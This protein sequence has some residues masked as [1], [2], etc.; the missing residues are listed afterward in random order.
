[1]NIKAVF[2]WSKYVDQTPESAAKLAE[3]FKEN[4][5]IFGS[6]KSG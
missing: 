6:F 2:D 5:S 4:L 1:M 3:I